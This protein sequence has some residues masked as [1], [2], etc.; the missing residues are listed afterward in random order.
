MTEN[1]TTYR[2][3][4]QQLKKDWPLWLLM[5]TGLLLGLYL[6]PQLSDRVAYSLEHPWASG[7]LCHLHLRRLVLTTSNH[8][9]VSNLILLLI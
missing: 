5:V 6:K 7:R 3:S 9:A 2:L 1:K 8:G 4:W